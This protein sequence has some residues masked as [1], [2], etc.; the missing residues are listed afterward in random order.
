MKYSETIGIVG[1]MG[2][3]ATL[4]FFRRILEAFPAEKE[5]D[6]PRVIIDNRCTMPSRV[7]AILYREETSAVINEL[8]STVRGLLGCG[9]DHL[10]FAC[11]TSHAFLRDVFRLVPE[12]EHKTVHIIDTLARRLHGA[13]IR[14]AYLIASEGTLQSNIYQQSFDR[15][16]IQLNVPDPESWVQLREFIEIVKQGQVSPWEKERFR[17]FC[18]EIPDGHIILGCTEFPVLLP[19]GRLDGGKTLWDPLDSAIDHIKSIIR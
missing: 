7:R 4:D 5:W 16:G 11:N 12:A 15:Y 2:S 6:R 9:A 3:Y 8:A 10:I 14:S 17:E 1:G 18:T 19:A 13:G